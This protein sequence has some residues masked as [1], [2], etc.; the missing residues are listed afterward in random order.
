M[1]SLKDI[2]EDITYILTEVSAGNLAVPVEGNYIGDFRFIREALEQII[3]FLN[4]T[5][6]QINISAE[7]VSCGSEQVSAGAQTLSRGL[8]NRQDPWRNW[9]LLS[10]TF[11]G[12]LHPMPTSPQRAAA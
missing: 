12:R 7:Q 9:Q 4:D 11:P 5:L 1:R 8:R 2:I 6:R 10:M 3:A